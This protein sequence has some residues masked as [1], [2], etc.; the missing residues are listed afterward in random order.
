MEMN[1]SKQ[2]YKDTVKNR[3]ITAQIGAG[4]K[5]TDCRKSNQRKSDEL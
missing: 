4:T 2:I 3:N 1:D 5:Q